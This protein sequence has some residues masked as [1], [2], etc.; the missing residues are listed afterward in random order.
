[1]NKLIAALLLAVLLAVS[2][3][4]GDG[5]NDDDERG[6]IKVPVNIVTLKCGVPVELSGKLT[7]QEHS[8]KQTAG[9]EQDQNEAAYYYAFLPDDP[10]DAVPSSNDS[11]HTAE[12]NVRTLQVED[13]KY[14]DLQK[15]VDKEVK[16]K[17]T[18]SPGIRGSNFTRIYITPDAITE[19]S[20]K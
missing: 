12:H 3:G 1:M 10:I 15:Y 14:M 17:G 16:I 9:S 7:V 19:I 11:I 13:K 8:G 2:S 5:K 6:V 4:C 18:L 20:G